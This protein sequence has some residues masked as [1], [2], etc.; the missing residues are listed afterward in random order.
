MKLVIQR[1]SEASVS[2]DEQNVGQID[3]GL[4]ILIGF[5]EGDQ[6]EDVEKM[7]EKLLNFRIFPDDNGQMNRSLKEVKGD[8]LLVPNFTLCSD[9][10]TG[11]R[12]GFGPAASP[13]RAEELYEDMV[14]IAEQHA[15]GTVETGEFGAMMDVQLTNDGPVTFV[16]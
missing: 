8:L 13:D 9:T 6:C 2:M 1:V 10:N 12:P 11:N 15:P 4:L 5:A 3:N 7:V 14:R 16:L